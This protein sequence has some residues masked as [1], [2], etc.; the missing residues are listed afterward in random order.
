MRIPIVSGPPLT[1]RD[2]VNYCSAWMDPVH[3]SSPLEA[4]WRP[5]VVPEDNTVVSVN[6]HAVICQGRPETVKALAVMAAGLACR[7]PP[8]IAMA[9]P[10][11][12]LFWDWLESRGSRI[13]ARRPR[14]IS[15][16]LSSDFSF[17]FQPASIRNGVTSRAVTEYVWVSM[18]AKTV[19]MMEQRQQELCEL[20]EMK[21]IRPCQEE[22]EKL[23]QESMNIVMHDYDGN[24]YLRAYM[25]H[26]YTITVG[27]FLAYCKQVHCESELYHLGTRWR[28]GRL[29]YQSAGRRKKESRGGISIYD[30]NGITVDGSSVLCQGLAPV[31]AGIRIRLDPKILRKSFI[32]HSYFYQ[33]PIEVPH[34]SVSETPRIVRSDWDPDICWKSYSECIEEESGRFQHEERVMSLVMDYLRSEFCRSLGQYQGG[35]SLDSVGWSQEEFVNHLMLWWPD[36]EIQDAGHFRYVPS[37]LEKGGI[38]WFDSG[39]YFSAQGRSAWQGAFMPM[40][41][42]L[43]C[44]IP[45]E[46]AALLKASDIFWSTIANECGG[47]SVVVSH[48]NRIR[49]IRDRHFGLAG[50]PWDSKRRAQTAK[51]EDVYPTRWNSRVSEPRQE[52]E[53]GKTPS[54]GWTQTNRLSG[55]NSSEAGWNQKASQTANP[56]KGNSTER[57]PP[58]NWV[59]SYTLCLKA[60]ETSLSRSYKN[61]ETYL[62]L[63]PPITN[64]FDLTEYVSETFKSLVGSASPKIVWRQFRNGELECDLTQTSKLRL[65]TGGKELGVVGRVELQW[66][67]LAAAIAAAVAPALVPDT[68]RVLTDW[69][70]GRYI[71]S[72][73]GMDEV[74]RLFSKT[75]LVNKETSFVEL[76][77]PRMHENVWI[78]KESR[79]HAFVEDA[80]SGEKK[81]TTKNLK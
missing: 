31:V 36:A 60:A 71:D 59:N 64:V 2:A 7:I 63:D 24:A 45:A 16:V 54:R 73:L 40:I 33:L 34:S 8:E 53:S 13:R 35:D 62:S 55:R 22:A 19:A 51:V 65:V 56:S 79:S 39:S 18:D 29:T 74:S 25:Q 76:L 46:I 69:M 68:C 10:T 32:F 57:V 78:L 3:P 14:P 52:G 50:G 66:M 58:A 81:W 77:S 23:L 43:I 61:T 80:V 75:A 37:G 26:P 67:E 15:A 30:N 42:S 1:D 4:S 6:G 21:Y 47:S 72:S 5:R 17:S 9:C 48:R 11:A 49:E 70:V 44:G 38:R 27:Q 20:N 41:A 12:G 28:P